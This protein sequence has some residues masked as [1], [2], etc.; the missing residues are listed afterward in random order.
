LL[1]D[2]I[3]AYKVQVARRRIPGRQEGNTAYFGLSQNQ[4]TLALLQRPIDAA[5]D[6]FAELARVMFPIRTSADV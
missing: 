1:P 3:H 4:K 5:D 6:L 2:A